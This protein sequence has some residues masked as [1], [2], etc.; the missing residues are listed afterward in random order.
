[1]NADPL[2]LLPRIRVVPLI[3]ID[4]ARN[5]SPLAHALSTGGLP[6]AEIAFRTPAA[7]EALR[8]LTEADAGILAGAGTI[9]TAQQA[10]EARNAGAQFIVSPG[11]N[12]R[13][14]DYCQE[15]DI[16]I[17]PG[18]CTPTEIEA[19]LEKGLTTLKFFPAEAM[20]GTGTLKA[21]SGP[22]P[23]VRF[24][25]TGGLKAA[26]LPSYLALKNVVACGG[27]WMAPQAWIAAGE[28]DRIRG[29]VEATVSA[30]RKIT[31]N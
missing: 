2:M 10:A 31:E 9:L 7:G 6:C 25:P 22:Y 23:A 4:D 26:S 1:M 17:Y 18:V 3:V 15:H 13:V 8:R 5:A 29:A 14:V 11:F 27:S 30:V 24:I 16:P 12:P 21:I 20:G 28:F 19:A